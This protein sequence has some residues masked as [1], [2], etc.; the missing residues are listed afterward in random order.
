[1]KNL[2]IKFHGTVS[3]PQK[4]GTREKNGSQ[5][6]ATENWQSHEE[7]ATRQIQ[8]G[9]ENLKKGGRVNKWKSMW[10]E[11]IQNDERE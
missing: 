8:G 7:L 3:T 5:T 4:V 1:M 2:A 10:R 9:K 11:N 6:V